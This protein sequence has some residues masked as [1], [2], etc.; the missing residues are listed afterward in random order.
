[1][2]KVTTHILEKLRTRQ[3]A[4][5]IRTCLNSPRSIDVWLNSLF[6]SPSNRSYCP[7]TLGTSRISFSTPPLPET[8]SAT[9]S[10][11]NSSPADTDS[12]SE[13]NEPSPSLSHPRRLH[14]LRATSEPPPDLEDHIRPPSDAEFGFDSRLTPSS[15]RG[16]SSHG[17][18]LPPLPASSPNMQEYS[19]EWGAFPTPS[20]VKTTFGKGGRLDTGIS[21]KSKTREFDD[22]L[23]KGTVDETVLYSGCAKLSAK[24]GEDS[25]F[26][27]TVDNGRLDFELSLVP[28]LLPEET[29]SKK[30]KEKEVAKNET[31]LLADYDEITKRFEE[32]KLTFSRFM[33][34]ESLVSNP[35]LAIKWADGQYVARQDSPSLLDA[36]ALWR[37][38]TLKT[39]A[40]EES[41]NESRHARSK[42]EPPTPEQKEDSN[43]EKIE[44]ESVSGKKPPSLSWVQWWSRSRRRDTESGRPTSTKDR[45]V[46]RP[47]AS[48][49]P[50][51][52]AVRHPISYITDPADNIGCIGSNEDPDTAVGLRRTGS[53]TIIRSENDKGR[54]GDYTN[55]TLGTCP[56]LVD[57]SNTETERPGPSCS[58]TTAATA[59]EEIRKD[60][61]VDVGPACILVSYIA[62]AHTEGNVPTSRKRW[63]SSL[64]P[65]Q[66][67]SR[68]LLVLSPVPRVSLSGIIR[69]LLWF[70]ISTERSQ[71]VCTCSLKCIWH[72]HHLSRKVGWSRTRI[73]NDWT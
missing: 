43:V 65:I 37:A 41:T 22:H 2:L 62:R 30:G 68:Y 15:S 5:R 16:E 10:T 21:R 50:P 64:E 49:P 8:Q 1:M 69:I 24:D 39:Q 33:Q 46:L 45:P 54:V 9:N 59:E 7:A 60:V 34:D 52:G 40:E 66:S 25:T 70:Q 53:W 27:L 47:A 29:K 23:P 35:T 38:N 36:L 3:S 57:R 32:G 12:D 26:L 14:T 19:W 56:S 67:H 6:T 11:H 28:R 61:E 58:R 18:K 48:A 63:T 55:V 13:T 71:S 51:A 44:D 4:H 20:P 42:S 72:S 17:L 73:R 31:S